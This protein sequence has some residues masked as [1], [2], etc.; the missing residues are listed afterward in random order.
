MPSDCLY[1]FVEPNA[2]MHVYADRVT[3]EPK[4]FGGFLTKG[5]QGKKEI[6][7]RSIKSVQVKEAGV[8]TG[9][10]QFGV[11]GGVEAIGGAMEAIYDENSFIFGG[12]M[13]GKNAEKNR[14]AAEIAE[15]IRTTATQGTGNNATRS[16]ADE[17]GKLEQLR[18][19][20][21]LSQSEFESAKSK[22]LSYQRRPINAFC[23][24]SHSCASPSRRVFRE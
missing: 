6:P 10:I 11:Q 23:N 1:E 12:F 4:G 9:Y 24:L 20:G 15:F 5:L 21:V 13:D 14:L 22:L 18:M 19:G 8:T 7:L 17:L 16:L 2:V 3:L